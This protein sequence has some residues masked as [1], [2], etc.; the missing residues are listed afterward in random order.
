[1]RVL[2]IN[3]SPRMQGNTTLALEEMDRVFSEAGIE[4]QTLRVGN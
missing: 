3:G 1:M 4:T 2:M